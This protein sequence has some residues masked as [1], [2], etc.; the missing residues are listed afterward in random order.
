V[1]WKRAASNITA[2]ALPSCVHWLH[3]IRARAA[4]SHV[5]A[6]ITNFIEGL[7][8]NRR[9]RFISPLSTRSGLFCFP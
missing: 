5:R 6:R 3:T 9:G 8:A 2:S 4:D 1:R 7:G